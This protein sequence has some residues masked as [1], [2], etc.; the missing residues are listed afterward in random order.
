MGVGVRVRSRVRDTVR[1]RLRLRDR[2]RTPDLKEVGRDIGPKGE[3][4]TSL[5]R[6][7]AGHRLVRGWGYG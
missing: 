7:T 3:P 6:Q 5:A 4:H 2:D 1:V